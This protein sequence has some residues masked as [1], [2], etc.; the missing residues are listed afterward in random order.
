MRISV[1]RDGSRSYL[2]QKLRVS[3]LSAVFRS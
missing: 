3:T 1:L 2:E